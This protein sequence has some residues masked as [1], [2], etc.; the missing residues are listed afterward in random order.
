[1]KGLPSSFYNEETELSW[2]PQ[3]ITEQ[4]IKFMGLSDPKSQLSHQSLIF[5]TF[6]NYLERLPTI[7]K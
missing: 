1:M 6:S 2:F 3:D 5:E 7:S 4:R